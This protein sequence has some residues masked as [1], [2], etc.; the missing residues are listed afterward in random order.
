MK[1]PSEE[2]LNDYVDEL[3]PGA[4]PA[5]VLEAAH[6]VDRAPGRSHDWGDFVHKLLD[7]TAFQPLLRPVGGP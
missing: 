1:H 2:T 6:P 4:V 3:L 5:E 7:E